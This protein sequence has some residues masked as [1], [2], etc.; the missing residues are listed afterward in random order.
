MV[1]LVT[2][3]AGFIGSHICRAL[4]DKGHEVICLDNFDP[5]YP[6]A[7]KR[8]NIA[9]LLDQERLSGALEFRRE[10]ETIVLFL[11]EGRVIDA[12]SPDAEREP[13]DHL[14]A[15]MAWGDGEFRFRVGPVERE[16][17]IGV[18]TQG[19]LLDLAVANDEAAR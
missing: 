19:L 4:L 8:R 13:R 15:L 5:Y 10:D 16:D 7:I 6:E 3:G 17:R 11:R 14:S 1:I 9:G 12:E 2:G 18:P